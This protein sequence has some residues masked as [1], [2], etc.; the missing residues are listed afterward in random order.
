[1]SANEISQNAFKNYLLSALPPD[2][3]AD[4]EPMLEPISL[5]LGEVLYESGE[6]AEYLYFP[7]TAIVSML[8]LLENGSTIEVG[9]VGNDGLIGI[10]VLLGGSSTPSR[11]V[12]LSA[13]TA[14]RMKPQ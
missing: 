12:I 8:Y 3:F 14:F 13:G 10:A 5:K 7:T 1:M 9:M 4:I 2:Y 11:A 6:E